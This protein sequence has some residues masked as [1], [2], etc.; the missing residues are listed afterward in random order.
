MMIRFDWLALAAGRLKPGFL[1][2]VIE[3]QAREL[4]LGRLQRQLGAA[5]SPGL[6]S[7]NPLETQWRPS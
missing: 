7:T 4:A 1:K 6:P 2:A 5:S 3:A